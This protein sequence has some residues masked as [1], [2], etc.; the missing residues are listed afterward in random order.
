MPSPVTA[1]W[2]SSAPRWPIPLLVLLVYRPEYLHAWGDKAYH[3]EI[4]LARLGGASSAAMVRAILGKSYA[5]RVALERL[6][7]E[8]SQTM[9]RQLLGTTA[10]PA[11]LEELVGTHTDGNPLFIEELTRDLLE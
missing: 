1:S 7:P 10:I 4:S 8:D 2:P 3:A 9:V 11:E 5:A 6:S